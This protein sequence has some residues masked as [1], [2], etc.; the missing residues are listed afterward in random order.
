MSR[1]FVGTFRRLGGKGIYAVEL[2][3]QALQFGKVD[4]AVE[5]L[6]P[7][8]LTLGASGRVLYSVGAADLETRQGLMLAYRVE[9]ASGSLVEIDRRE[10]GGSAACHIAFAES[11]NVVA[12]ANYLGGSIC[13]ASIEGHGGFSGAV[14]SIPHSGASVHPVRQT[15]PHPHSVTFDPAGRRAIA[16]DLGTDQLLQYEISDVDNAPLIAQPRGF[17]CKRGTGPRHLVFHP[18]GSLV[19]VVNELAS[20]VSGYRY[21]PDEGLEAEI[22]TWSTLPSGWSG[23]NLPAAIRIGPSGDRLYVSNRG[24]NSIATFVIDS[25]TGNLKPEGLA[26]SGGSIPRDLALT[27]DGMALVVA[28]QESGSLVALPID[29]ATGIPGE[30]AAR[31]EIPGAVSVVFEPRGLG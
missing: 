25:V 9:P 5:C 2:D 12:V 27:P 26:S 1:L 22:G 11:A 14:Q 20:S 31:V 30:V 13:A 17:E 18:S 4:V 29:P 19:Y 28:N 15:G 8:Y 10:T 16:C 6:D 21:T 24:H 23:A 3:T 7:T